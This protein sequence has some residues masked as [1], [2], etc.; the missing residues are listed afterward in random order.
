VSKPLAVVV[1]G[2]AAI[3]VALVVGL[4]FRPS[5]TAGE[6]GAQG[7]VAAGS[8]LEFIVQQGA[9]GSVLKTWADSRARVRRTM[10]LRPGSTTELET[11]EDHDGM[12]L[13]IYAIDLSRRLWRSETVSVSGVSFD[14]PSVVV[15]TIREQI[16]SGTFHVVG[17]DVVDGHPAV[18]LRRFISNP[19]TIVGQ[20][21][22]VPVDEWVDAST[23]L[24]LR[25]E[26]TGGGASSLTTYSWVPRTSANLAKLKLVLPAG[27]KQTN[28]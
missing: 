9:N 3:G 20:I 23:Y 26:E 19:H 22:T 13:T 2:A 10:E 11:V 21:S 4:F 8:P 5:S 28:D 17:S 12:Q 27:F 14:D 24:P 18:H 1:C 7:A 6:T 25:I 15:R 16:R